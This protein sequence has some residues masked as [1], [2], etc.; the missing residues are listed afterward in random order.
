MDEILAIFTEAIEKANNE[1]LS[2]KS[3]LSQFIQKTNKISNDNKN[4]FILSKNLIDEDI[5]K[6]NDKLN[7]IKDNTTKTIKQQIDMLDI[8]SIF[9]DDL[10]ALVDA[11]PK[12]KDG[13][14]AVIDYDDIYR[15]I[16]NKINSIKIPKAQEINYNVIK[17]E[18]ARRVSEIQLPKSE[19][20]DYESINDF[21]IKQIESSPQ[22]KLVSI[23]DIVD[24]VDDFSIILTNG[25][26]FKIKKLKASSIMSVGGQSEIIFIKPIDSDIELEP[27][28]QTILCDCTNGDII[29]KLPDPNLCLLKSFSFRISI[30]KTDTTH[31]KVIILPFNNELIV[32]EDKQ[33]LFSYEVINLITD[34]TNWHLGA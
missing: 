4:N 16:T 1:T 13:K 28:G 12:A 22:D 18:I 26:E 3:E 23:K 17:E 10:R 27:R 20:V 32:N 25:K 24:R 5:K 9:K 29:V 6:Q 8:N 30:T 14:D 7:E 19:Q 21:I 2:I 15:F 34:K 11:I 33:E 31:N